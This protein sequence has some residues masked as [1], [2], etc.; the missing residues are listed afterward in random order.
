MDRMHSQ[1]NWINCTD[2]HGKLDKMHGQTMI[3]ARNQYFFA[4]DAFWLGSTS[5]QQAY[6]LPSIYVFSYFPFVFEGRMWDL[7][8]SV[9]DHC[10]SFYL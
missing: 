8:E 7:I 3:F 1:N 5:A 6:K 9:P 4:A 10:L 2:E